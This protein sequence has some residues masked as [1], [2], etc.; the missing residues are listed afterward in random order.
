[1]GL[2]RLKKR[3]FWRDHLYSL[4]RLPSNVKNGEPASP[5]SRNRRHTEIAPVKDCG[6]DQAWFPGLQVYAQAD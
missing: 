6:L 1:M 2:Q 3:C 5:C 4:A